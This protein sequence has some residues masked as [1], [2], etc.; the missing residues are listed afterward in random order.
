M[1]LRAET[2]S[3]IECIQQQKYTNLKSVFNGK[4]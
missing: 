1:P 3:G 4:P 2:R